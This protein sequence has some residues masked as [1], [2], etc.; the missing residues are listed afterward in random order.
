M[1]TERVHPA[2]QSE[3][4]RE[5]KVFQRFPVDVESSVSLSPV[6][7]PPGTLGKKKKETNIGQQKGG[8]GRTGT[9]CPRRWS[10][11]A[12]LCVS[13]SAYGNECQCSSRKHDLG[14]NNPFGKGP[15]PS[16]LSLSLSRVHFFFFPG[17]RCLIFF[18]CSPRTLSNVESP[19]LPR[20][21]DDG[22]AACARSNLI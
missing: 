1:Y 2:G 8:G 18:F 11:S 7:W 17:A 5:E 12:P 21:R 4:G 13:A 15:R 16:F 10:P 9:F 19:V 22:R 6:L 20:V 3:R 14:W